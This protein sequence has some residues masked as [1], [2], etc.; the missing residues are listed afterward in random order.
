MRHIIIGTAGHVDHGKT[1]LI[2]AL[3]NIDCDTHKEE[4]ERGITINL[5]FSHILLPNGDSLGIIDVP[6][7]KDFIKIM[8]AGAFGIDMVLLVIAADSG[9]MPQTKEH[10]NIVETL[11]VKNG[12]VVLNKSDL[13]DQET[14]ELAELEVAEYLEGSVFES[15]P[16][17]AV[18][19]QT[20]QGLD[21]LISEI[22]RLTAVISDRQT[23]DIFRMYIDRIFTVSGVGCVV[24]GSVLGGSLKAGSTLCLGP[25][26]NKKLKVRT[27]ERHGE[28]VDAVQA[29]DRAALNLTGL[30][31]EEYS[32]GMLLS[33][34]TLEST[35]LIDAQI[36][37]FTDECILDTWSNV[38]FYSGTFECMAKMHLLDKDQLIK[39]EIAFAQLHLDK[40]A[41]LLAKDKFIIRN[42]SN[43][44]SL[45]GGEILDIAP[46]HHRKRTTKLITKLESLANAILY[47]ERLFDVIDYEVQKK[48]QPIF[49]DELAETLGQ[50][51]SYIIDEIQNYNKG[52]IQLTS[53]EDKFIVINS[54]FHNKYYDQILEFL[55]QYHRKNHLLDEGLELTDFVGK[56]NIKEK[57][58]AKLYIELLVHQMLSDGVIKEVGTTIS[59][60]SHQV[61]LDNKSNELHNWLKD[62]I[63]SYGRHTPLMFEIEK[64]A[65]SK[66]IS[67]DQLKMHLKYLVKTGDIVFSEGEYI[68]EKHVHEVKQIL[69]LELIK[70]GRGINEKDF[71]LLINSSKNFVK[72]VTRIYLQLGYVNQEGFYINITEEGKKQIE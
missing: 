13:V 11:G 67:K 17:V 39:G 68:H 40:S 21:T 1:A 27:I 31:T 66:N 33:N 72:T 54:E 65:I 61:K 28:T 52:S 19:S 5:G 60:E 59:L 4:K 35:Q 2:K 55:N 26:L 14:L 46:L 37:M 29:G 30:K 71:R 49:V 69:L 16:I 63:F 12:I 6:G 43:T 70:R 32:R 41:C 3:T 44:I 18:S 10:I 48:A 42:S 9:I 62:E 20:K 64:S 8:V 47:S 53:K 34:K 57:E 15:A 56:V 36:S 51:T 58:L 45:G 50:S 23:N 38:I 25:D 7:H 24:T 22:E